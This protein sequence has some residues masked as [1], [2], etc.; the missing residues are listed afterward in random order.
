MKRIIIKNR[1][2][3]TPFGD[4]QETL[5]GLY[6]KKTAVKTKNVFDISASLAHTSVN[7]PRIPKDVVK[8]Y[9]D[10]VKNYADCSRFN[11]PETLF[12]YCAAKGDINALMNKRY[13]GYSPI[14]GEQTKEIARDLGLGD[15][16]TMAVSN[17]CAAGA[18]ALDTARLFLNAGC[19]ERAVIFGFEH[20]SEFVVRGFSALG[21]LSASCA[22]PFDKKR[23]GMSLGEGSGICVLEID[24]PS[25]DDIF[26]LG[27]GGS[28]DA[29]HRTGPSKDGAGLALAIKRAMNSANLRADEIGAIKCH[30]TATPYNDAMEAKALKIIFGENIPPMVSLKGAMGHLSGAGA[31]I[32]ALLS[33]E[34][35][36]T[37]KIPA[38][39]NFCEFE[40]EEKI[41][42][43]NESQAVRGNNILCL[44]AG[45]G[46]INTAL[47][48]SKA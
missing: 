45:F 30:G 27:S 42:I 18:A 16:K 40:G 19:L 10:I 32:E 47:I 36:K 25:A 28:N 41:T 22:K 7:Y 2:V 23:D 24:E 3:I 46:G 37:R 43:S 17:A 15:C 38:T 14:L 48:L 20:I 26:V 31:L 34:F 5:D 8:F 39:L 44:S 9:I 12:I 33:A 1:Q 29:H 6:A 11:S 35:L 4:L 21:A 13:G